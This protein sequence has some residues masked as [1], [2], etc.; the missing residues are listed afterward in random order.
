MAQEI[1]AGRE[2]KSQTRYG[3]LLGPLAL[4]SAVNN[5]DQGFMRLF[6]DV[7]DEVRETDSHLHGILQKRELRVAS[8]SIS[9]R[10][11]SSRRV[12]ARARKI[13]DFCDEV[14]G[15]FSNFRA[16]LAHLMNGNYMNR[17]IVEIE[18]DYVGKYF[19][20]REWHFIHSRRVS[21]D[22]SFAPIMLDEDGGQFRWPG[23][24][25]SEFTPGK[26]LLFMP[27]IRHTYPTR[28]G[29]G[30]TVMW[31]SA[32]KRWGVRDWL[33]LAEIAAKPGKIG[34][35][36]TGKKDLQSAKGKYDLP[37]ATKEHKELLTRALRSFSTNIDINLP[38][39]VFLD[40]VT[41][42]PGVGDVHKDLIE[43]CNSE[44]S[45]AVTGET[46]STDAGNRGAR[47]L[48]EVHA[49]E[50][51]MIARWDA[52]MIGETLRKKFIA[53]MVR[54]N[55]GDDAPIPHIIFSVDPETSLDA[56]AD[57]IQKLVQS[58]LTLASDEVRGK[59]GYSK[60]MV[61]EEMMGRTIATNTERVKPT[62]PSDPMQE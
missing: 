58:G 5:A 6:S 24:K 3:S 9:V 19:V 25:V 2:Q 49:S 17:S 27:S 14:I 31:P 12:T 18:W 54:R 35:Y 37:E 38:D 21:F 8:A 48:G 50:A 60:P 30:R 62:Y 59:F 16:M 13:V 4:T 46:L 57:R 10:A 61:D 26:L 32:F 29:L 22:D 20:P 52:F 51:T 45:K 44:M 47:S 53:P 28:E 41:A 56:E 34:Y 23:K 7:L 15:D 39:S 42:A 33:A 11:N 40:F 43:W 1:K 55:F 36:G